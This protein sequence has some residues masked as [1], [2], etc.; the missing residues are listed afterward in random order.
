MREILVAGDRQLVPEIL[1]A[2]VVADAP[3]AL[4]VLPPR[5]GISSVAPAVVVG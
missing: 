1:H 4:S 3:I 2:V 5:L